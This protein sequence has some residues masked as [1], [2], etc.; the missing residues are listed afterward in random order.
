MVAALSGD[1]HSLP[2][3]MAASALRDDNWTVHHLGADLPASE[4]SRFCRKTA[5]DLAVLTVTATDCRADAELAASE[6]RA[7]GVRTIVGAPG[8]TLYEL[9]RLARAR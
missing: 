9:Q 2:S 1:R 4:I 5:V 6:L 8:E 3:L 7:L